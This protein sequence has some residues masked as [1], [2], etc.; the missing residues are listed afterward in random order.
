VF[1]VGLL[2]FLA[3]PPLTRFI[4]E[5]REGHWYREFEAGREQR[6]GSD[7]CFVTVPV[8]H[9]SYFASPNQ[10]G[11][12]EYFDTSHALFYHV[13]RPKLWALVISRE[14]LVASTQWPGLPESCVEAMKQFALNT[15]E[16]EP[17]ILA[18]GTQDESGETVLVAAAKNYLFISHGLLDEQELL[19]M[20]RSLRCE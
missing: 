15:G 8:K 11:L 1:G 19:T 3:G 6:V 9:G 12:P 4:L 13:E 20:A 5:Q 14:K 16:V 17:G 18:A 2:T 10:P 7:P